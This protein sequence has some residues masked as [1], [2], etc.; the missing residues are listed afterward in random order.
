MPIEIFGPTPPKGGPKIQVV[1]V[2]WT[3]PRTYISLSPAIVSV[4]THFGGRSQECTLEAEG[5]CHG[6]EKK[7]GRRWKGYLDA[8]DHQ[9]GSRVILE[10][11][12]P[13]C[14]AIAL[15]CS[16]RKDGRGLVFD[17]SK[18]KGGAQGRFV[19]RGG[20]TTVPIATLPDAIDPIPVLRILWAW[21][22]TDGQ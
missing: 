14:H 7:Y 18:S 13:A 10:L 6:C 5:S 21:G 12:P 2:K 1:R 3:S 20:N 16:E 17:I 19:V 11:T 15:L 8:I 9:E 22:R 4:W